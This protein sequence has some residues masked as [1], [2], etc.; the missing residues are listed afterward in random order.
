MARWNQCHDDKFN[1]FMAALVLSL[2]LP[3]CPA[4]GSAEL[5]L[6]KPRGCSTRIRYTRESGRLQVGVNADVSSY[7]VHMRKELRW[8]ILSRAKAGQRKSS[9]KTRGMLQIYATNSPLRSLPTEEKIIPQKVSTWYCY[10]RILSPTHMP[11]INLF[12]ERYLCCNNIFLNTYSSN[13]HLLS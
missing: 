7:C 12:D 4:Q 5:I 10:L 1:K 2:R 3:S 13:P 11:R 8:N 9:F 6:R